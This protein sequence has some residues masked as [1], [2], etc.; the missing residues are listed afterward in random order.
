MRLVPCE[1]NI[2]ILCIPSHT[3]IIRLRL[4]RTAI[5]A[6]LLL[7]FLHLFFLQVNLKKA[8]NEAAR[9]RNPSALSAER[10]YSMQA[11]RALNQASYSFGVLSR[12]MLL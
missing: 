9:R 11:F 12:S 5:S 10:W 2:K 7:F 1:N 4:F 6:W 3:L 8:Y